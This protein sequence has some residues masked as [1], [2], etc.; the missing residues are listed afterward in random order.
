MGKVSV[1]T[2]MLLAMRKV[3]RCR[4]ADVIFLV[5]ISWFV[6]SQIARPLAEYW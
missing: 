6:K 5:C 1:H 2:A 3:H 4:L